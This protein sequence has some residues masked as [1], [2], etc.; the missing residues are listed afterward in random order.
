MAHA[1][2]VPPSIMRESLDTA[3]RS[4]FFNC[5]GVMAENEVHRC[6]HLNIISP[7]RTSMRAKKSPKY[8]IARIFLSKL[9]NFRESLFPEFAFCEIFY[10][11]VWNVA[12]ITNDIYRNIRV[13]YCMSAFGIPE[14][15][16]RYV[17]F[18]PD[19]CVLKQL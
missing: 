19:F 8:V 14:P 9:D 10:N 17:I 16:I 11:F 12:N 2:P 3:F 13:E 1:A 7:A 15:L 6:G 18:P 4:T 5:S